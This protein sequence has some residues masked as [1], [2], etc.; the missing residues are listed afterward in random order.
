MAVPTSVNAEPTNAVNRGPGTALRGTATHQ[1]PGDLTLT[2]IVLFT[3]G[4]YGVAAG[5]D[6][7]AG[8][9]VIDAIV[10]RVAAPRP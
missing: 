4:A 9:A 10:E 7:A 5:A 8:A 6:V 3:L 2:S 1:G